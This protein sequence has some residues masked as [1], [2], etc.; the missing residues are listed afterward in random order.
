MVYRQQ[1]DALPIELRCQVSNDGPN[2]A[3]VPPVTPQRCTGPC[4][5]VTSENLPR[6]VIFHAAVARI[7]SMI[8]VR[9]PPLTPFLDPTG[10]P[11]FTAGFLRAYSSANSGSRTIPSVRGSKDT[12][13]NQVADCNTVYLFGGDVMVLI[14]SGTLVRSASPS[15]QTISPLSLRTVVMIRS[16]KKS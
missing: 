8:S 15:K 11:S 16:R 13:P 4:R 14:D 5:R 3:P 7:M 1:S 9:E 6:H 12:I 2:P 10:R